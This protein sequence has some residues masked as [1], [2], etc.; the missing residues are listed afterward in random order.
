[1]GALLINSLSTFFLFGIILTIGLLEFYRLLKAQNINA[2][3]PLGLFA[4]ISIYTLSYLTSTALLPIQLMW[5][6]VPILILFPISELY[7]KEEFPIQNIGFGLMGLIYVVLPIAVTPLLLISRVPE[8]S[9]P[10]FIQFISQ[11]SMFNPTHQIIVF[12]GYLMIGYFIIQ[13][14]SDTGAFLFGISFGKHRLFERISPKKSWE[15]AIGGFITTVGAAFLVH[16]MFPEL[17][18]KHWVVISLIITLFGIFGDLV[19]SLFKRSVNIKDSG[20]ILPGHGGILDRFDSTFL[21]LPMVYVYLQ[22]IYYF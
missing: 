5:L 8:S 15:G 19:E 1:M 16:Y 17:A 7:R 22:I 18:L 12:N 9:S 4:G 11:Q 21:A 10:D 2:N 6:I 13:W 3:V 14:V 20:H